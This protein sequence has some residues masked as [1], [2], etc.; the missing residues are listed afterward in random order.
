M[1]M[2]LRKRAVREVPAGSFRLDRQC[3]AA[4]VAGRFLLVSGH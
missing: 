2:R 1:G 3:G 4:Q